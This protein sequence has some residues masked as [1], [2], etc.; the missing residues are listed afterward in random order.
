MTMLTLQQALDFARRSADVA[1]DTDAVADHRDNVIDFL[2]DEGAADFV[3][4]ALAQFDTLTAN[5]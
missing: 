3:A 4:Q 1:L 5:K 2:N